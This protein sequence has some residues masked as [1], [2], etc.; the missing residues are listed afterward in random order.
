MVRKTML[1]AA[2]ALVMLPALA[3]A[4]SQVTATATVEQ[5]AAVIGSGDVAFGTLDRVSDNVI[6]PTGASAAVRTLTY[7]HNVTVSFTNVPTL[8]TDGSL[9]L[10]VALTCAARIGAGAWLPTVACGGNTIDLDV[11]GA[12]TIAT[13]GFGGTITGADAAAAIAGSYSGM[14]DIVVTA[15]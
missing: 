14:F 15:R 6:D 8:L 5:V 4:Q 9:E 7:N 13:L 1:M 3:S 10:P 11:G 12:L 2:V